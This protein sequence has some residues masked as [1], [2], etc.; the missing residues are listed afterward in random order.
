MVKQKSIGIVIRNR[1]ELLGL[2]REQVAEKAYMNHQTVYKIE[3]GYTLPRLGSFIHLC[4]VLGL[5]IEDFVEE[6][7]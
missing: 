4:Y 3:N 1:R 5:K 7:Q 2:T 6:E